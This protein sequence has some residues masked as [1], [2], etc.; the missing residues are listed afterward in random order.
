MIRAPS[1][2]SYGLIIVTIAFL[3]GAASG[4]AIGALWGLR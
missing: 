1:P 2:P 4:A 3:A